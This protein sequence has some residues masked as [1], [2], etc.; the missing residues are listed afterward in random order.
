MRKQ[1]A[2]PP[3]FD[4]MQFMSGGGELGALMR[5]H[6]WTRTPLGAPSSW[7]QSL[8]LALRLMLN[9]L[10]PVWVGWGEEF[11]YFYNDAYRP[12]IGGRHPLALGRPARKVWPETWPQIGPMLDSALRGDVGTYVEAQLLIMERHGYPEETYYTWSYTPVPNDDGGPGGIFCANTDDTQRVIGERQ[13]A[14]L[15]ELASRGTNARSAQEACRLCMDA[16]ATDPRDLPF[17]LL[18]MAEADGAPLALVGTT[19]IEAGHAAA[20]A[21]IAPGTNTPW[22][23][24]DAL[25]GGAALLAS[26]LEKQF[27]NGLPQGVWERAPR[28]AAIIPVAAGSC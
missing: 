14:L 6:D 27:P 23:A 24:G 22:P 8:K 26:D 15:R 16:L 20:P 11:F 19:G 5:G 18:Y 10:Q 1:S 25:K 13:L 17:G 3:A 9:S 28:E 4:G 21:T 2:L 7:P 12:I